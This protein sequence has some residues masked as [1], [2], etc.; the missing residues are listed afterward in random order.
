[1]SRYDSSAAPY[2]DRSLEYDECIEG[3][4]R[5]KEALTADSIA[6]VKAGRR[7]IKPDIERLVIETNER[8]ARED[9]EKA[10]RHKE[11]LERQKTQAGGKAK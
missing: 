3:S 6:A 1:M 5:A 11:W 2:G 10:R 7:P 8:A 9:E 4:W